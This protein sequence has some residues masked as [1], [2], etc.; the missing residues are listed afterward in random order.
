MEHPL[1]FSGKIW[2]PPSVAACLQFPSIA[3]F[4]CFPSLATFWLFLSLV[5]YWHFLSLATF[6]QFHSLA[7]FLQFLSQATFRTDNSLISHFHWIYILRTWRVSGKTV[8]YS[9]HDSSIDR[10]H[11]GSGPHAPDA[12]RP[13]INGPFVPHVKSW[14]PC[15]FTEVA[16]VSQAYTLHV[17]WHQEKGAQIW[18]VWGQSLTFTEN[19]AQGFNK[20]FVNTTP[21]RHG[22]WDSPVTVVIGL[23]AGLRV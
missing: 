9:K 20:V 21:Y 23:W 7:T 6:W 16:D 5:T 10:V 22:D 17:L 13:W 3:T 1:I 15:D 19:V 14:E 8:S 18:S 4:W 2:Q 11:L 12:P